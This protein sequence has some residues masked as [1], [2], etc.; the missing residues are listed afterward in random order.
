MKPLCIAHRGCHWKCFENTLPAFE[1]ATKGD[2]FGETRLLEAFNKKDYTCLVE[3]HHSIKDE[4]ASFV[5][6]AP[7]SDDMT[8]LAVRYKPNG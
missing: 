4:V 5:G 2:F 1:A 6:D 8:L 7:Q 3:L